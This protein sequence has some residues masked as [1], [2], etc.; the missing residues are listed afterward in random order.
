MTTGYILI[1]AILILGGAIAT[2]GDRIGTRVGKARLSLFN[3]RPRNTAIVVTILT[4]SIISASTLAILFAADERL[5]T[6]VFELEEIQDDLSTKRKQLKTTRQQLE[7]TFAEKSQVQKQ[8]A[9]ARA[10]QKA[11]QKEAQERQ[12]EAQKRL[13]EINQSLQA[14]IAKQ[15]QTEVQ[16]NRTQSQLRQVTSQFEQ[17]QDRLQTV[18]KQASS[19]RSEIQ[20]LQAERQQLIEQGNAVK[21]TIA[22]RDQAIAKLDKNIEQRDQDIAERDKVIAQRE[23]R[24]KEL[25]TQQEY[26]EREVAQL[27]RYYQS[28][29]VLRQGNV[30]LFRGHVLAAAVVRIVEPKAAPQAVEQLLQKAN[31]TA[32]QLTRPSTNLVPMKVVQ[33]PEAQVKQLISQIDDGREYVVRILSAGNYVLGEN[34]VQV[35]A[36][37]ALNQVVFSEGDV[38]A[39]ISADPSSMT[40]EE[41]NQRIE[42]LLGASKFRARRA[43]ILGDKIKIGDKGIESLIR[44]IVRLKRYNEPVRLEAVVAEDTYTAGPLIV[45]LVAEQNGKVVFETKSVSGKTRGAVKPTPAP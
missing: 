2:M 24:L 19:L 20:Q 33:I 29:Q 26:L 27:E 30:S 16:L 31:R 8:L 11:Q 23:T 45:K 34:S 5:R 39:A 35:F 6:G 15:S 37:A 38:L 44:F 1:A 32:I 9:Q 21:A 36:D 25:E 28:Y 7:A 22:Q 43:G 10:E 4:G 13:K 18:T 40:V 14:A 12:A 3:L 17:A 42:L 41:L